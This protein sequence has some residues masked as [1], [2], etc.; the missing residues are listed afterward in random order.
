MSQTAGR[1]SNGCGDPMDALS[2]ATVEGISCSE[3]LFITTSMP[4]ALL[5]VISEA[6]F[7]PAGVAA[8]PR[9]RR[10]AVMFAATALRASSPPSPGIRKDMAGRRSLSSRCA[11][12]QSLRSLSR[13]DQRQIAPAI[14]RQ[15]VTALC[16]PSSSA[17]A[18]SSDLPVKNETMKEEDNSKSQIIFK[19]I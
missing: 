5:D 19:D 8:L 10:F 7:T 9:P 17:E 11:M 6:A 16:A 14:A 4:R 13:P 1:I 15:S 12:P 18:R 2:A 3:L